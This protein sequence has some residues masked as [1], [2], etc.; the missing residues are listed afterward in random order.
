MEMVHHNLTLRKATV[1]TEG[2]AL[3]A[4]DLIEWRSEEEYTE[5]EEPVRRSEIEGVVEFLLVLLLL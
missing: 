4:T 1:K 5:F 3:P 2:A